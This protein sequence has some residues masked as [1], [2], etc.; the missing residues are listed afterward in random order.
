MKK[1]LAENF[2]FLEDALRSIKEL[3]EEV[4]ALLGL[5][6]QYQRQTAA[7]FL[8]VKLP[9]GSTL[10]PKLERDGG[11][12]KIA[13]LDKMRKNYA[14]V[15]ELWETNEAISALEVKIR[16]SLS[17]KKVDVSP[18]IEELAKVRA[19]IKNGLQE[20]FSFLADLAAS[21]LPEKFRQFNE[22]TAKILE[23]SIAYQESKT[24]TYIYE[25]EGDIVFSTYFQLKK[26]TDDDGTYFPD[27]FIVISYRTGD[28]N[29]A[30][31]YVGVLSTFVPPSDILLMKKV[32]TVKGTIRALNMLLAL[33]NFSTSMGSLPISLLLKEGKVERE[34]FLYQQYIKSIRVDEEQVVFVLKPIITDKEIADKIIKSIYL[35]FK[36]MIKKTKAT[37]RMAI[38]KA[39]KS[40]VLTFFFVVPGDSP[41]ADE[42]DLQ[43]LKDRFNLN[44]S[45]LSS[46]VR[47]INS[48]S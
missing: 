27:L 14:V 31:N 5:Q 45:T 19:R 28:S 8:E 24:F 38:R 29:Q 32:D 1:I 21:N 2:R 34:L 9:T 20:A 18:A 48:N 7:M 11:Q 25:V 42:S 30:G 4:T 26:V 23:K 35:D 17:G 44:D 16:I 46:I 47:T 6:R 41:L 37:P 15:H 33:D 39:E 12:P 43:F 3:N 40:F 22:A 10:S 36:T 13:N